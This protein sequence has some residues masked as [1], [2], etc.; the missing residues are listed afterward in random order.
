MRSLCLVPSWLALSL[1][2]TLAGPGLGQPAD[3]APSV[4]TLGPT[5]WA[6]LQPPSLWFAESN[7]LVV[8]GPEA[9]LV[10]DVPGDPDRARR[11]AAT[12]RKLTDRPLR[13]LV[14]THWHGDHV[15]G[16]S[17]FQRAFGDQ[18]LLVG[19]DSLAEDVPGRAGP[20]LAEE[21]SR[22]STVI[23]TVAEG[24][25]AGVCPSG[26]P[27]QCEAGTEMDDE[28]RDSLTGALDR[29]RDRLGRLGEIELLPPDL[30]FSDRLTLDLGDGREV[31]L[32]HLPGHTRGDVV[33]H[34]PADGVIAT[35][36]LLDALPFGG[37]GNPDA[38]I[39][40]LNRLDHL[41][42][43][44]AVPGHGGL[45]EGRR[46]LRLVR[47]MLGYLEAEAQR[48]ASRGI[49]AEAARRALLA[50]PRTLSF[51]QR[52]AGVDAHAGRAFDQFIPDTFDRF[53]ALAQDDAP[54]R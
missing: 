7:S 42:W 52:L 53:F 12:V 49:P 8:A 13:F 10:V 45:I 24:L 46:S 31:R 6:V 19:H 27:H 2:L 37:H 43:T 11:L 20:M 9:A 21:R 25:E 41:G 34:L 39:P 48:A 22:L 36:D 18:M 17:I 35:G 50:D 14:F 16:A 28:A 1:S 5:V 47:R 44:V 26:V 29:A 38:W 40:S 32:H 30:T 23:E 3:D 15:Q 33:V 4:R 54:P 51:R